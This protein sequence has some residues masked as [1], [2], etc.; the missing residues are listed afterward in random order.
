M[1]VCF[2]EGGSSVWAPTGCTPFSKLTFG[3]A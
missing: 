1:D 3:A 2:V